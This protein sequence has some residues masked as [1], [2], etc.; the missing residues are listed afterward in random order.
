MLRRLRPI[1]PLLLLAGAA[2]AVEPPPAAPLISPEALVARQATGDPA[3]ILLDVRTPEEYAAG[4]VP[5]AINV[6]HD[7]LESRLAALPELR[8]HDL[9]VYCRTGRRAGF[10]LEMLARHGYT[11]LQHLAGD[12]D[13]WKAADRPVEVEAAPGPAPR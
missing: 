3:M 5:G 9:V 1:L 11:R 7:T 13:G 10:A 4:H 6:P 12:M 8:D 2:V